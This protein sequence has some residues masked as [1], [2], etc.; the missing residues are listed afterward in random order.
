MYLVSML[1]SSHVSA[2]ANI[3]KEQIKLLKSLYCVFCNKPSTFQYAIFKSVFK[4]H[5]LWPD[6][7]TLKDWLSFD[8]VCE[9]L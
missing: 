7:Y 4:L 6:C 1:S 2:N 5:G 3:S 9:S 8:I